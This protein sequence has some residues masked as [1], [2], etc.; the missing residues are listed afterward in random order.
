MV[1]KQ[2]RR[3]PKGHHAVADELVDRAGLLV[4]DLGNELEIGR[5]P[6]Q[7]ILG[8]KLFGKRRK[9][10]EV[11]E[12]DRQEAAM[13][14]QFQL[15]IRFEKLFYQAHGYESGKRFDRGVEGIDGL[16]K[17]RHFANRRFERR[18]VLTAEILD[19][20]HLQGEFLEWRRD[21]GGQEIDDQDFE[22]D[23][24]QPEQQQAIVV[25]I[26]RA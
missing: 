14:A 4:D 15:L 19:L 21:R 23:G 5:N 13:P 9:R 24:N 8:R 6:Q 25:P 2:G 3:P 12:E 20:G 26:E 16:G 10:L 22:R 18:Q 7:K 11:G 1:L 17:D